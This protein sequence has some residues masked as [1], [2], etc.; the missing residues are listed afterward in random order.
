MEFFGRAKQ[1]Q[2]HSQEKE[3]L[4]QMDTDQSHRPSGTIQSA[5]I[6]MRWGGNSEVDVLDKLS[7]PALLSSLNENKCVEASEREAGFCALRGIPF[8]H[9]N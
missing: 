9:Q 7:Q 1:S 6:R 4:G 8:S 3:Y 5:R 2:E